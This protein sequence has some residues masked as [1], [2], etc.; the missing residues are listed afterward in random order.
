MPGK[1]AKIN[2]RIVSGRH[3]SVIYLA[4]ERSKL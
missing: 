3:S 4:M 2:I 1:K